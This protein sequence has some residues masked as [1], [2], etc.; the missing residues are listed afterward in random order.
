MAQNQ[1]AFPQL[2]LGESLLAISAE[3]RKAG[4]GPGTHTVLW[5]QGMGMYRENY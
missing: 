2:A 5:L 3:K 1:P 4:V